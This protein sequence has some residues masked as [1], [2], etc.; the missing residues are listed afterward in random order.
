M[1]TETIASVEAYV[2]A[3]VGFADDEAR[4]LIEQT[5]NACESML[6]DAQRALQLADEDQID[7]ALMRVEDIARNA[8]NRIPGLEAARTRARR[9]ALS[10]IDNL[11]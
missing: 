2:S 10:E 1:T 4:K 8:L 9:H 11:L 7:V 3:C 6:A 5:V